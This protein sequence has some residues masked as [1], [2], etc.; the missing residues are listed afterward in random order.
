[1][2]QISYYLLNY[3]NNTVV[4]F[5]SFVVSFTSFVVNFTSS[6]I[7]LFFSKLLKTM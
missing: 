7:I 6:R 3:E 4:A 5:T 2:F 1:M